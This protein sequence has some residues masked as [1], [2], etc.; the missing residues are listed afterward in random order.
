METTGKSSGWT[1]VI[2]TRYSLTAVQAASDNEM[3]TLDNWI[4]VHWIDA[5]AGFIG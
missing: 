4:W 1:L 3:W 5:V 2:G